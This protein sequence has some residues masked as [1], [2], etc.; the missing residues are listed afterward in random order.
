MAQYWKGEKGGVSIENFKI[1]MPSTPYS[2]S[3]LCGP[4][5]DLEKHMASNVWKPHSGKCAVGSRRTYWKC[6]LCNKRICLKARGKGCQIA[7]L[8]D[9]MFGLARCN[10]LEVLGGKMNEL[11]ASNETVKRQNIQWI[12]KLRGLLMKEDEGDD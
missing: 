5:D 2:S 4:L 7:L 3:R 10:F 1:A 11:K 8:N 12:N 6:W 9:S